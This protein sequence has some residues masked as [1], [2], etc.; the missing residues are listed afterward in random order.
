MTPDP[1]DEELRQHEKN[2]LKKVERWRKS[3]TLVDVRLMDS[4]EYDLLI[5]AEMLDIYIAYIK[6]KLKHLKP[7]EE[8]Y[9][10]T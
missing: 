4:I 9:N 2:V 5:S 10:E 8:E 1:I 3:R 7:L 6:A